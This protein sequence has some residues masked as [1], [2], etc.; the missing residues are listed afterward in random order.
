MH[1]QTTDTRLSFS[2]PP[3]EPEYEANGPAG[4]MQCICIAYMVNVCG[5]D[6]Q[7]K[8]F[9][10]DGRANCVLKPLLHQTL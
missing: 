9:I 10:Y 5:C 1:V 7:Q 6:A 2:P 4:C 3:L 8:Y